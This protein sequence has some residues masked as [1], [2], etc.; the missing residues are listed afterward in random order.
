MQRAA[1][2]LRE[3]A[4]RA[5]RQAG[6]MRTHA[7]KVKPVANGVVSAIGGTASKTDKK[8]VGTLERAL[9]EL[10]SA[11]HALHEAARTAEQL[12]QEA[13]ARELRA[14]EARAA[15]PPGRR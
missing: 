15:R 8:I 6:V 13:T 1:R 10:T 5:R 14:R 11:E 9:R 3:I 2:E 12:S 7:G 4:S